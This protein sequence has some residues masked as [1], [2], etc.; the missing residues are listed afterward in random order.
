M[1]MPY[2]ITP[3]CHDTLLFI[4]C[5]NRDISFITFFF[6][7]FEYA[8]YERHYAYAHFCR[9]TMLPPICR[10]LYFSHILLTYHADKDRRQYGRYVT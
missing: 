9:H 1:L 10:P 2:A 8:I 6:Y 5:H 7:Y 4:I 3:L